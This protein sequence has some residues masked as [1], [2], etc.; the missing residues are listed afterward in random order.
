[1]CSVITILRTPTL[2]KFFQEWRISFK[3]LWSDDNLWDFENF[4][5]IRS[6]LI[7]FLLAPFYS[8]SEIL[9]HLHFN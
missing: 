2:A 7:K 9:I 3:T 5:F 8:D 4:S 6:T 1:M